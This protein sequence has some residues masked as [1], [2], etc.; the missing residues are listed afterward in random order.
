MKITAVWFLLAVVAAPSALAQSPPAAMTF[1]SPQTL[2]M[3]MQ[4]DEA[5]G[6]LA[7]HRPTAIDPRSPTEAAVIGEC[8]R[9]SSAP[10]VVPKG[11]F[12]GLQKQVVNVILAQVSERIRREIDQYS[13]MF[14]QRAAIDF[15][16]PGSSST[17]AYDDRL[18]SRYSC[19]RFAQADLTQAG[20]LDVAFDFVAAIGI[21][22]TQDAVIVRPLRLFIGRPSVKSKDRSLGIAIGIHADAIWR[23][24][25]RGV[26]DTIWDEV[27]L[28]DGSDLTSGPALRY[29]L[30]GSAPEVR[31]PLPPT[32]VGVDTARPYGRIDVSVTAAEVGALP[33]SLEVLGDIFLPSR[34]RSSTLLYTA[35]AARP[36]L[37]SR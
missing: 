18:R 19:F 6:I 14:S 4:P 36:Q 20:D 12:S 22:D 28:S 25:T 27:V 16:A 2:L 9:G 5:T 13:T 23:E 37:R 1:D 3:F 29:F 17:R 24:A 34:N 7:I 11:I 8:T 21:A 10:G 32:S 35:A 26:K 30:D 15:Y 31:L 33:T